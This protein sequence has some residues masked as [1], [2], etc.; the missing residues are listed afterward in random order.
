M[1]KTKRIKELEKKFEAVSLIFGPKD[2][3]GLRICSIPEKKLKA[4][5]E[6]HQGHHTPRKW[7]LSKD[8]N[9]LIME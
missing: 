1:V 8:K 4:L 5:E 3:S 2:K 7:H 9:R 6:W